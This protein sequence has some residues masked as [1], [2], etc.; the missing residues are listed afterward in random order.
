MMIRSIGLPRHMEVSEPSV[1][2]AVAIQRQDGFLTMDGDYFWQL[3][4]KSRKG[5]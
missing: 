2:H 1:S 5:K 4:D 3:T